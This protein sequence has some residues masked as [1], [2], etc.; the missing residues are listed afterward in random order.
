L[1]PSLFSILAKLN[2]KT[3]KMKKFLFLFFAYFAHGISIDTQIAGGSEALYRLRQLAHQ[4][5]F[6]VQYR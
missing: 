3:L 2:E 5:L 1:Q 4:H 6:S